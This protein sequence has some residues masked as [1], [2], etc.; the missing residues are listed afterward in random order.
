MI[1]K[2]RNYSII[3]FGKINKSVLNEIFKI[4]ESSPNV[5]SYKKTDVIICTL[6]SALEVNELDDYLKSFN[7]NFLFFDLNIG[8]GYNIIDNA[9]SEQLFGN[10]KLKDTEELT[11]MA[12]KMMDDIYEER[13]IRKTKKTDIDDIDVIVNNLDCNSVDEI[14]NEILDK[15]SKNIT[16]YDKIIMDNL[17]KKYKS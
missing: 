14:I 3:F 12:N 1:M 5:F 8:C 15:G 7:V 11:K 2:F 16:E 10:F 6:S 13:K 17:I 9:I 4:S